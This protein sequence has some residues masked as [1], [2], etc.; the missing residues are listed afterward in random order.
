[1]PNKKRLPNLNIKAKGS[2][3][4]I[5]GREDRENEML[6]LQEVSKRVGRGKLVV[7]TVA[8]SVG[9]ELWQIYRK[10]FRKLGV[11]QISHL[12]VV[13]RTEAVDAKALKAIEGA[14]GVFFT[15]GDQLK[16]TSELGG[17]E[18]C[19][20]IFSIYKNGGV[21][22]GTSAG[23]SVMSETMLVSG[24]S[25]SSYR[26]G[27]A[28]RLAP[29]LGLVPMIVDQHFAE[30]GR[31]SRL[32]GA[33][34]LNPKYLGIGIDENTALIMNGNA[35]FEV[36]GRGAVYVIDAHESTECNVSEAEP[37]STLSIFNVKFHVLCQGDAFDIEKRAPLP[38]R[39][40]HQ[41]KIA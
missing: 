30:R 20:R 4:I 28:L 36:L 3:V 39:K 40:C 24:A 38:R 5:G 35:H 9:N 22:A 34:A 14:K 6:I 29:G 41:P 17:T 8:S 2:L 32:L 27:S 23:A 10:A 7:A 16:I 26:I 33:V 21:I 13:S 18:I 12:D 15:G 25:D 1:M 11:K 31:V 19:E 37:D